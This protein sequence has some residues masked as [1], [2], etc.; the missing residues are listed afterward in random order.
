MN[1]DSLPAAQRSPSPKNTGWKLFWQSVLARSYPRII[2]Q[3]RELS[4]MFFDVIMPMI[5][6]VG[7]VMVYK[8]LKAPEEYIGF[9]IIGGAMTAFWMNVLWS[10]SS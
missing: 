5:A 10:M 8:A 1:Q 6:V 3:Q 7:Y 2:G 4:W 9:V